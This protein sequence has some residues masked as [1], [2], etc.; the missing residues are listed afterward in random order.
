MVESMEED[1]VGVC[2]FDVSREVELACVVEGGVDGILVGVEGAA[3]K[4]L[5]LGVVVPDGFRADFLDLLQ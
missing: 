1:V 5:G 4:V 2:L 3:L